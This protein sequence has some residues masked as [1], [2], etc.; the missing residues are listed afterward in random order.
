MGTEYQYY[1]IA[2][3]N[4]DYENTVTVNPD[5]TVTWESTPPTGD[6]Y[7]SSFLS[8]WEMTFT[9]DDNGVPSS[10]SAGV[11]VWSSNS[12]F[13]FI[14]ESKSIIGYGS[15]TVGD[16]NSDLDTKYGFCA[17]DSNVYVIINGVSK[18]YEEWGSGGGGGVSGSGTSGTIVMW[19]GASS[20]TTEIVNASFTDTEIRNHLD[21][22]VDDHT[23][24]YDSTRLD[25]KLHKI[26]SGSGAR[27]IAHHY[28]DDG[29]TIHS[30]HD[31]FEHITPNW[32]LGGGTVTSGAG[33]TINWTSGHYNDIYDNDVKSFV[34]GSDTINDNAVNYLYIDYQNE[35]AGV[36]VS[37]TFPDFNHILL[38]KVATLEGEIF[39]IHQEDRVAES[40]NDGFK[41]LSD[42]FPEYVKNGLIIE[43]H[44][45]TPLAVKTSGGV[46]YED[47]HKKVTVGAID[48]TVT[49]IRRWYHDGSGNWVSDTSST[50]DTENYDTGTGLS[51]IPNNKYV[52]SLFLVSENRIHWIYPQEYFNTF[53]EASKSS[54]PDIPDGLALTP[55]SCLL[56]IQEGETDLPSFPSDSW[57]DLRSTLDKEFISQ[58]I[59]DHG[60]LSGLSDDDHPQYAG[61]SQTENITGDWTFDNS[62]GFTV[63]NGTENIV[64][65]AGNSGYGNALT[66]YNSSSGKSVN[67][68]CGNAG[69][70]HFSTDSN[71]GFYFADNVAF[72][73]TV[74]PYTD[75]ATDL[76]KTDRRWNNIYGNDIYVYGNLTIENQSSGDNPVITSNS[77]LKKVTIQDHLQANGMLS[78]KSSSSY[79]LDF[80]HSA[81]GNRTITFQDKSYTVA[82]TD[83]VN[84]VQTDLNNH[85]NDSTIHFTENSIDH[86]SISGL[87]DDDHPQYA[88][89]AQNETITGSWTFDNPLLLNNDSYD[90]IKFLNGSSGYDSI[91]WGRKGANNYSFYIYNTTDSK[92]LFSVTDDGTTSITEDL[93][94]KGGNVVVEGGYTD[95]GIKLIAAS[96]SDGNGSGRLFF[97]ENNSNL[98]GF[99]LAYEGGGDSL[100]LGITDNRFVFR[101]HNNSSNGSTILYVNRSD[102]LI[103]VNKATYFSGNAYTNSS[104][105]VNSAL[106]LSGS[107][108][109]PG[110]DGYVNLGANDKA[111]RIYTNYGYVDVG[112]KNTSYCHFMTDRASFYFSK[113]V[114]VNGNTEPYADDTT[115]LG[116]STKRWQDIYFS[117]NLTDGTNNVPLSDVVDRL[118]FR[119]STSTSS[120]IPCKHLGTNQN[121]FVCQFSDGF[122]RNSDVGLQ[123]YWHNFIFPLPTKKNT[124]KL[125]LKQLKVHI[126]ASD[127]SNYASRWYV[128]GVSG[129]TVTIIDYDVSSGWTSAG[130][131]TVTIDSGNVDVSGYDY[132]L[133]R[134][135][136]DIS[137]TQFGC[138]YSP[139]FIQFY[140]A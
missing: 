38:A 63:D 96:V 20:P 112:P 34:S 65:K 37:T 28:D 43:P 119:N 62:N 1:K 42:L 107:A 9:T 46:Y 86:G 68:G 125:Y 122:Y 64:L 114:T 83:D 98:Y 27:Y 55:K 71:S 95:E 78:F 2:G 18:P 30:V 129:T 40:L 25:D 134:F 53:D 124:L 67:I 60:A 110:A 82:G 123:N 74:Y 80:V 128:E 33:L 69:W 121:K 87:G 116:S 57:V 97:C 15:G 138:K 79:I 36:Q 94:V 88:A 29:T 72:S 24:Y 115:D 139:P 31:M 103:H 11:P 102:G 106:R 5:N 48:S 100:G 93:T 108:V 70:V 84:T 8:P 54:V 56:I 23:Q 22:L 133:V 35:G 50:V 32:L 17:D 113:K 137:S 45:S 75:G 91:L 140:Y 6:A 52:T 41:A 90:Q 26:G 135:L 61:I 66:I 39:N 76:G 81:T 19:S 16:L 111:L 47:M 12:G 120:W 131:K 4:N 7:L 59:T 104:L 44:E 109:D 89:L 127:A 118:D 51:T 130:V 13:W 126:K 99:S 77:T 3:D 21:D 105:Y 73:Q 92:F 14:S 136:I 101:V 85:K 117:G 10:S 49:S 58:P 132:I